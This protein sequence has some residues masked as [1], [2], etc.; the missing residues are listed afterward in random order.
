MFKELLANSYLFGAN[1]PFIISGLAG[2]PIGAT[3]GYRFHRHFGVFGEVNLM[4][5][6]P[7]FLFN[8]DITVGLET[9]F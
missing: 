6:F 8:T 3:V 1:A 9:G 5:Q 2:L 4:F 7:T